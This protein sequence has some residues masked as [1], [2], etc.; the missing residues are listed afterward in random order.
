MNVV[1]KVFTVLILVM[2]LAFMACSLMLY[3]AHPDWREAVE[4]PGGLDAQLKEA[5][6]EKTRLDEEKKKL[7]S[8]IAEEKERYVK[9]LAA[10]G[11]SENR[12]GK[13]AGGPQQG[14]R[15]QG[16]D[17]AGACRRDRFDPQHGQ[18]DACRDLVCC[19]ETKAAIQ[20][21]RKALEGVISINDDL[22]NAVAERLRLAKL[23]H[24][25]QAQLAKMLPMAN[26]VALPNQSTK[27]NHSN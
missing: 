1:G 21:R 25:L 3:A 27:G 6:K 8:R 19:A 24:E 7:E 26:P 20:A 10:H 4:G 12:L 13:R 16:K 17:A 5:N 14:A 15:R 2:S 18:V 11:T 9:R 23:G 22:L